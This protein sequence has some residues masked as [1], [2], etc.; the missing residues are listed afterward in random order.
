MRIPLILICLFLSK[1]LL[2]QHKIRAKF[3]PKESYEVAI[4]Y[5]IMPDVLNYK[6]HSKFDDEGRFTMTLDS[7]FNSAMYR[8]VYGLPQE[9]HNFD[10][11]YN[12]QE[13]I[14]L[15]FNTETGVVFIKSEENRIMSD[16]Y[17]TMAKVGQEIGEAYR[18]FSTDTIKLMQLFE[19]QKE[20]QH[21]FEAQSESLMASEFIRANRRYIPAHFEP[22]Q[23]YINNVK[24]HYFDAVDFKNKTLKSSNFFVEH[25][26]NFLFGLQGDQPT[27]TESL[28]RGVLDLN[29][30]LQ[31]SAESSTRYAIMTVIMS[32]LIESNHEAVA[33]HLSNTILQPLAEQHQDAEGLKA[34]LDFER[35]ALGSKAPNFEIQP[36]TSNAEAI[37][38][39]DLNSADTYVLIFWSSTCSHCLNEMPTIHY[40]ADASDTTA[41]S[42]IAVALENDP[43]NWNDYRYTWTSMTHV[44][45]LGKW[46][47][48]LVQLYNIPAT[49]HFLVL[50]NDKI[51]IAKPQNLDA[52]LPVIQK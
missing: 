42:I 6:T 3:T 18:N 35:T 40:T 52:L 34:L 11:I 12:G 20:I 7:T 17:S 30:I 5:E 14:E 29:Q 16:Y 4:L 25:A 8:L 31:S 33:L 46:E 38:L 22:L 10:F 26:T 2:A 13:D 9:V 28:I 39:Y 43:Y 47:H 49:P 15:A 51:I 23:S 44:L 32:Q 1:S 50:N 24:S 19:R 27:S 45:A 37:N 41:T 36:A 48:P 21:Q